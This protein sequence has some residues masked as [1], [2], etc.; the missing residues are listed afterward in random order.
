MT[1]AVGWDV[2]H[3]TKPKNLED[4]L[5][6]ALIVLVQPRK[7]CHD[8]TEKLLTGTYLIKSNSFTSVKVCD[9]ELAIMKYNS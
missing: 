6:S 3:Q 1:I 5:S 8:M 4:T 2:K 7:S 9:R